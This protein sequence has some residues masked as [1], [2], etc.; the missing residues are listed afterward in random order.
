M[1]G[2]AEIV[3]VVDLGAFVAVEGL[4]GFAAMTGGEAELGAMMVASPVKHGFP[5]GSTN[6]LATDG[7]VGD[8]IFEVGNFADNWP[9]NDTESGDALDLASVVDS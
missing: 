5:E 1:E 7:A 3:G 2:E 4:S 8:E 9:H 6:S